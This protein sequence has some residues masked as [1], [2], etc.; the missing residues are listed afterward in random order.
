MD[1]AE[2][3]HDR[4][5][6]GFRRLL[7]IRKQ[8]RLDIGSSW[9]DAPASQPEGA[10]RLQGRRPATAAG[11]FPG[12]PPRWVFRVVRTAPVGPTQAVCAVTGATVCGGKADPLEVL[13]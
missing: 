8:R 12:P 13:N 2:A 9:E 1:G 5:V 10:H 11:A 4:S 3:T 6:A 7:G